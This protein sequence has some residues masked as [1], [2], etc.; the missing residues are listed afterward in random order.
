M[1]R[2]TRRSYRRKVILFGVMLFMSIA[3]VTTGFAAFVMSSDAKKDPDSSVTVGTVTDSSLTLDVTL[4]EGFDKIVF[5]AKADDNTGRVRAEQ[6]TSENPNPETEALEIKFKGRLNR[7][8]ILDKITVEL[9]AENNVV[10]QLVAA[11]TAGYITLPECFDIRSA[12]SSASVVAITISKDSCQPVYESG[13]AGEIVGYE[14]ECS[15]KFGWGSKF[16]HD[17]Q[18]LNPSVYYDLAETQNISDE[19]VKKDLLDMRAIILGYESTGDSVRDA[20]LGTQLKFK[21]V[22][23]AKAN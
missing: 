10:Q 4:T 12:N 8:D 5:G 18:N 14:F 23:T 6:A 21:I 16:A 9:T 7:I 17:G 20:E 13:T 1:N 11:Q 2:I 15:I 3:L 22:V 19:D